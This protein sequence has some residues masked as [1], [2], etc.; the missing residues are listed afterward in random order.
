[1][2]WLRIVS[3]YTYVYPGY[4]SLLNMVK[5]KVKILCKCA[6]CY[7]LISNLPPTSKPVWPIFKGSQMASQLWNRFCCVCKRILLWL[8]AHIHIEFCQLQCLEIPWWEVRDKR[9]DSCT[10]W[11][12]ANLH[13]TSILDVNLKFLLKKLGIRLVEGQ[14]FSKIGS[15]PTFSCHYSSIWLVV[16]LASCVEFELDQSVNTEAVF[17]LGQVSEKRFRNVLC[18]S[19]CIAYTDLFRMDWR[20]WFNAR[21]SEINKPNTNPASFELFLL[22]T[23]WKRMVWCGTVFEVNTFDSV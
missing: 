14:P 9:C 22:F 8:L 19:Y 12:N 10:L 18:S 4:R 16:K 17:T 13:C 23:R 1:M 21:Q 20:E 15:W 6:V 3:T 5:V 11:R 7:S 2:A